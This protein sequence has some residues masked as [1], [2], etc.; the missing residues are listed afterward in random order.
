M[1]GG[2]PQ[3]IRA[4]ELVSIPPGAKHWHG[5]APDSAMN[6]LAVA[7]QLAGNVVTWMAQVSAAQYG[8]PAASARPALTRVG[9]AEGD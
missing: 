2:S 1:E 8:E 5:A 3:E 7:E 6:H 9:S 4:G